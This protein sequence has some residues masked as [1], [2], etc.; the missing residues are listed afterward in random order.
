[1][2][3]AATIR[4]PIIFVIVFFVIVKDAYMV[5]AARIM[6]F[7]R[8]VYSKSWN[9]VIIVI[10][11][12]VVAVFVGV[13]VDVVVSATGIVHYCGSCWEDRR[14]IFDHYST[15]LK[16]SITRTIQQNI[17]IQMLSRVVTRYV[18]QCQVSHLVQTLPD[19]TIQTNTSIPSFFTSPK[20]TTRSN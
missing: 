7:R 19:I 11:I 5:I 14:L 6:I 9:Y 18:I 13:S 20:T 15:L 17:G 4:I 16:L 10:V 12:I 8:R 2:E 1:M 3:S